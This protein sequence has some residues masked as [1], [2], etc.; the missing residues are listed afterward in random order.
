M[1][2]TRRAALLKLKDQAQINCELPGLKLP[3]EKHQT[4][5]V[6]FAVVGKRTLNLDFLGAGKT[7]TAIA[8]DLKLRNMGEVDR[9]LVVCQGG[10]RWDWRDEYERF[11]DIPVYIIDGSKRQRAGT[12]LESQ[13]DSAVTIAHYQTVRGD[14]LTIEK[15]DVGNGYFHKVPRASSLLQMLRYD[16]IIFDEVSIFKNWTTTLIQALQKLIEHTHPEYC[17]GLSATVIQKSLEDLHSIMSV[18][19]PGLLGDRRLYEDTYCI[20]RQFSTYAGRRKI[21]F[22]KTIGFKNEDKLAEI[23]APH[24]IRREKENVYAGRLKYVPKI[25]RVRLTKVQADAYK[26]LTGSVDSGDA[27]GALLQVFLEME[28]TCD[29]MAWFGGQRDSAKIADI[30]ELLHGDLDGEKVV[31]FSKHHKPLDHLSEVLDED[32]ISY[33]RYSGPR[34]GEKPNM[35]EREAARK[36]FQTDPDI[37]VALVTAAAEMGFD[38]HAAH[39]MIFLN[40]IYNPARIDQLRGRIDRPIVQTSNFICTIHYVCEDTFEESII[41]RMHKEADLMRKV[42]GA[43]NTFDPLKAELIEA[44]DKDQLYGLIKTGHLRVAQDTHVQ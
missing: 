43:E 31:I 24:F 6:S 16:F 32:G 3:L 28:K 42:F 39:Y 44:L 21:K 7:V 1:D 37:R 13:A 33:I 8:A 14:F 40:H 5:G 34:K 2:P 18:I 35:K 38:F 29:T 41:P 11:T 10:K 22:M 19:R 36:R 26:K 25:R 9:T 4:V 20:K 27:R 15:V 23:M 12:W 17:L 30:R